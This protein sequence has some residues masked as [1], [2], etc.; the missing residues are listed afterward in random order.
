MVALE[1]NLIGKGKRTV[2]SMYLPSTD[3]VTKEDMGELLKQLPAPMIVLGDFN[4]HNPL[5]ESEKMNTRESDGKIHE[6]YNLLCISKE[7]YYRAFDD[8]KSAI[9]LTI[10]SLTIVPEL[11]WCKE[12]KL[13]RSDYFPII[14][15]EERE[16]SMK[17]QR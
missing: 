11:E 17:Q 3:Q 12:Y 14:I 1:V 8:N 15:E 6:N 10:A 16:I 7:T 13:K 2:C 5:W 9:D 4:A